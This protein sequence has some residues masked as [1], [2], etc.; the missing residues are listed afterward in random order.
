MC[1]Q[2]NVLFT[3]QRFRRSD[4]LHNWNELNWTGPR[5]NQQ[6]HNLYKTQTKR[7]NKRLGDHQIQMLSFSQSLNEATVKM[8]KH[9]SEFK[10]KNHEKHSWIVH[11]RSEKTVLIYWCSD[12]TD[13]EVGLSKEWGKLI[14]STSMKP[15]PTLPPAEVSDCGTVCMRR[16]RS[17]AS[18]SSRV[19]SASVSVSHPFPPS[20]SPPLETWEA[21]WTK[22]HLMEVQHHPRSVVCHL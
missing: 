10:V 3:N 15:L 19:P 14:R 21:M 9:N 20:A 13:T 16:F 22:V 4:L 5:T 12:F 7:K 11:M 6:L 8:Q 18:S 1:P 17:T 2:R